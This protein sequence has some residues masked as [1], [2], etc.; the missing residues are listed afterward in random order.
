M[1]RIQTMYNPILAF[2]IPLVLIVTVLTLTVPKAS[3]LMSAEKET[4]PN[5]QSIHLIAI[6]DSLT[7]GIG[8]NT[9][10]GGF[11]P[12]LQKR[13]VEKKTFLEVNT[14][15]YGK[16][17]D[18]SDQI[19][20]RIKKNKD[21]QHDLI[22]ADI[23]TLTVGGN[24]LMNVIKTNLFGNLALKSFEKPKK[25]YIE[26]LETLYQLIRSY[27]KKAPIYQLGIYNPFYLSFSNIKE[28]QE[29]VN[30]W[31][32]ASE[33]SISKLNAGYFVPI[34]DDIYDGLNTT[35]NTSEGVNNLLSD[36]DNFHPNNLGYQIIANGFEKKITETKNTWE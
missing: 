8:D 30:S 26:N 12:L 24:D 21:L 29:I 1:K 35:T 2:I 15:N 17:G 28:M 20:E 33:M 9:N 18:R 25:E 6:G 5:N 27:N 32:E 19:I 4:S 10:S 34:N 22:N 13:L 23:I 16:S 3:P 36:T 11:V 31:N 7:E 14:Q